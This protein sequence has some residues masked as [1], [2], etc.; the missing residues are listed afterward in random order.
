MWPAPTGTAQMAEQTLGQTLRGSTP[1]PAQTTGGVGV[2]V[3]IDCSSLVPQY[4]CS[5]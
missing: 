5:T 3:Q 4:A 2:I 1:A